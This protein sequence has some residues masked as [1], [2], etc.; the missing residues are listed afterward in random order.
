M[1]TNYVDNYFPNLSK[2]NLLSLI[3]KNQNF[4]EEDVTENIIETAIIIKIGRASCRERV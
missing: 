1:R 4:T 3:K 2:S